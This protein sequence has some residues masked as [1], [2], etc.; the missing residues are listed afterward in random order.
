MNRL[1]VKDI[2]TAGRDGLVL[3]RVYCQAGLSGMITCSAVYSIP[4]DIFSADLPAGV[5][6]LMSAAGIDCLNQAGVNP[7]RAFLQS[8]SRLSIPVLAISDDPPLPNALIQTA[9]RRC[10]PIFTSSCNRHLLES[11]IRGLLREFLNNE[12]QLPGCLVNVRGSGVF[13]TGESGIGKTACSLELTARG[14]HWVSD[15]AALLR[16]GEDGNLYGRSPEATRN[17][18]AIRGKGIRSAETVMDP[19]LIL[20]ETKIDLLVEFVSGPF[21]AAG[22]SEQGREMGRQKVIGAALP[23]FYMSSCGDPLQ[24]AQNLENLV[25][26]MLCGR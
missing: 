16:R 18:L 22:R 2:L 12:I 17:L 1:T 5:V 3:R 6:L 9:R 25:E 21:S 10:F 26:D 20:R 7:R 8:L 23:F 13:I 19:L 4:D 24:M 15:D 14:H 11:R